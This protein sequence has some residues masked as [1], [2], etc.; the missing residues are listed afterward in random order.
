MNKEKDRS[1]I[2]IIEGL[3]RKEQPVSEKKQPEAQ[4]SAPPKKTLN[5]ELPAVRKPSSP[6]SFY[7]LGIAPRLL[8]TLARL[9]FTVPTPI[10]HKTIPI[11]LEGKD[12]IGVAQTGTGK[13]LAFCIPIYQRL[14][15]MDRRALVLVPTR[16]LAVQVDE[17]FQQVGSTFG[18]RTAL[19]IG[20]A[21]MP[22]QIA[23]LR[24]N[25]RTLIATP[26]RLIDHIR[27][28]TVNIADVSI[29]VLDE[30]DRMLDMGFMPQIDIL[31]Q[32]VN[33]ERQTMLFSATIPP[34]IM[35]IAGAYMKLPVSVEIAPSGTVADKIT[36]ELFVISREAKMMLL[37]KLLRQYHGSVLM[38]TRT[39]HSAMQVARRL[40]SRGFT[41]ADI[42]SNRSLSQRRDALEGFKSGKY[43]VLVATDIA[44]RGID[45]KGIELVLN[46]DIPEDPENYVHRIGR[47]GRIGME[48]HAIT[49]ATREQR[50]DVQNI[51]RLIKSSL[52]VLKHPEIPSDTF[53]LTSAPPR[54]YGGRGGGQG[55]GRGRYQG[56]SSYQGNNRRKRY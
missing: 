36:Q 56:N 28:S 47:T 42:Q 16:E 41:A 7:G 26:G 25:P 34:E 49:F 2:K 21:P 33:P 45:V 53:S 38:F 52:K 20:G 3:F 29:V 24:R 23:A 51:E 12:I 32:C 40:K 30:A 46:Y 6:S 27:Q 8:E 55:G 54:T 37:E 14:A 50:R 10:Q 15:Q 9:K 35:R 39:K 1:F 43:R 31:F 19:I 11:A 13:T 22:E 17:V 4:H 48:G 5:I 18:M 44:S